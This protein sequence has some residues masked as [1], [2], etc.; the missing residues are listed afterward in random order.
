[1]SLGG[2]WEILGGPLGVVGE[3]WGILR[4]PW[5]ALVCP[6]EVLGECSGCLWR[7][8]GGAWVVLIG[9]LG[10]HEN[11]QNPLVFTLFSTFG[12]S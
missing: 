11:T 5:G 1:M 3:P 6:L 9:S 10:A 8:L 2:P 7:V 4:N 12:A